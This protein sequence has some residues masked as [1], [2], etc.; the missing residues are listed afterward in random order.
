MIRLS[1][2]LEYNLGSYLNL[3]QYLQDSESSNSTPKGNYNQQPLQLYTTRGRDSTDWRGIA[4]QLWTS[5]P[6]PDATATSVYMSAMIKYTVQFSGRRNIMGT[7][8]T[9]EGYILGYDHM[10]EYDESRERS[11]RACKDGISSTFDSRF[12][13]SSMPVQAKSPQALADKNVETSEEVTV[14]PKYSN[15]MLAGSSNPLWR[16]HLKRGNSQVSELHQRKRRTS[17]TKRSTPPPVDWT[18]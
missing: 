14:P 18:Q 2:I 10:E 12:S 1:C 13:S 7:L 11:S 5:L 16:R 3:P 17:D 8:P 6:N 4:F 15:P 9:A